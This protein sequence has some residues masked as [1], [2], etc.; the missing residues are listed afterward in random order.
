MGRKKGRYA[1]PFGITAHVRL[2]GAVQFDAIESADGNGEDKLAEVED[3]EE[4]IA[5]REIPNRHVVVVAT[6]MVVWFWFVARK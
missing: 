5:Q 2:T 6:C 1:Y 4:H 3:C